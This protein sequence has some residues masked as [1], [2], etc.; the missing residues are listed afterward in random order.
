MA[1]RRNLQPKESRRAV[2]KIAGDQH[3]FRADRFWFVA[4]TVAV[5]RILLRGRTTQNRLLFL[6]KMKMMKKMMM[7]SLRGILRFGSRSWRLVGGYQGHDDFLPSP[8][9][10][11]KCQ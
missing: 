2:L 8:Q 1:Q 6:A 4:E 5:P 3:R 10:G 7:K 11:A 9:D